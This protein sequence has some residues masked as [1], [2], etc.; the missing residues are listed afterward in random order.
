MNSNPSA[1]TSGQL[2]DDRYENND[3]LTEQIAHAE[4]LWSAIVA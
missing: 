4:T 3:T 1:L 2:T